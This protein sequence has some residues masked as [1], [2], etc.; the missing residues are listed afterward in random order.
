MNDNISQLKDLLSQH[1]K[2]NQK[3]TYLT[4]EESVPSQ[5]ILK[6]SSPNG[7][8]VNLCFNDSEIDQIQ[9]LL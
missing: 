5:L 1:Y 9:D 8:K 2:V 4:A 6:L 3:V 7:E